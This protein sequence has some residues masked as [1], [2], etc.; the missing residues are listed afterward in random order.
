MHISFCNSILNFNSQPHKEADG[1]IWTWLQ[2]VINFNSQPHKE[3]DFQNQIL[4]LLSVYFNSQPHKEADY[5]LVNII[6]HQFISTHSLTRR[7]TTIVFINNN[8]L[9]IS[10]HS[11]TRRLTRK[12]GALSSC[13]DISTHSLTRRLTNRCNMREIE[14]TFQLTASQGG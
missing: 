11:L 3:A 10:T 12:T 4:H 2:N 6:I 7:L 9:C 14:Q 8:R 13:Y 5:L 1:K